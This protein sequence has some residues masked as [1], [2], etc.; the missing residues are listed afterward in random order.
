M[1]GAIGAVRGIGATRGC[2][3]CIGKLAGSVGT[4]VPA[5]VLVALGGS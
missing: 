5:W 1:S 2:Q 3:G 4:Q